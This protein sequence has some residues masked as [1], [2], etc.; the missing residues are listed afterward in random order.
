MSTNEVK[1][2]DLTLYYKEVYDLIDK[3]TTSDDY[4]SYILSRVKGGKKKVF[5][6]TLTEIRD[7]DLSFLDVIE[8][9]YPALVKIMKEPKR[10]I[11]YEEEIV[12][13]EKAR[14]VNSTTVKHLSSHTHLIKEITEQGDVIPSKVLTTFTEDELG[15]YENRFIKSLVKRIE[16][17]LDRRY[18]LMKVS[19]D[20][21]VT[22]KLNVE[23]SFLASGQQIKVTID[24]EVKDDLNQD[25]EKTKEQFERLSEIRRMI[26]GLK[27]TEFMRA[28]AKAKDVLPPIMKTNIIMLN[29]DF[30]MCFNLWLYL[31]KID[32]IQ[33]NVE[34]S[35]KSYRYSDL[36]NEDMNTVMTLALTAFIKNREIEGIYNSKNLPIMKAPK[37]ENNQEIELDPT[38]EADHNKLE[39]YKMNELLL[40]ETAKYFEGSFKGLMRSGVPYSE[41]IRVVYRQML[42]MLDQIYHRVFNVADEEL[43]AKDLHEQIEYAR[44]R[45][46]VLQAVRTQKQA[47]VMGMA[48]EEK[49]IERIITNLDRKIEIQTAKERAKEEKRKAREEA[50]RLQAIAKA[51]AQEEKRRRLEKEAIARQKEA[52][53]KRLEKE[54]AKAKEDAKKARQR[55]RAKQLAAKKREHMKTSKRRNIR[56]RKKVNVTNEQ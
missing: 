38:L 4:G 54:K 1:V 7:F 53:K 24:V 39:D 23:N 8:S 31:D 50:L 48:R 30:R 46:Q 44:R 42:E 34:S 25:K 32:G 40:S 33:T 35:E 17:F 9:V 19:L 49:K 52:E 12:A 11:R 43:E 51:K 6:K 41:S 10:T 56:P 5:N 18:D 21:F 15:I 16:M 36:L 47:N 3:K 37:V 14:K 45:M 55:E 26:K 27:N 13:V 20:S 2:D 29:P 28:L 22:N